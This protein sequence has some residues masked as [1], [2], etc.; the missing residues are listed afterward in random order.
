MCFGIFFSMLGTTPKMLS[1]IPAMFSSQSPRWWKNRLIDST[2]CHN[3]GF[4]NVLV[5]FSF[6]CEAAGRLYV[7][8]KLLLVFLPQH[9]RVF[10]SFGLCCFQDGDKCALDKTLL[11]MLILILWENTL[12]AHNGFREFVEILSLHAF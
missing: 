8:L 9:S 10:V 3:H 11:M 7:A 4:K 5:W 1:I 6:T 12:T 2:A